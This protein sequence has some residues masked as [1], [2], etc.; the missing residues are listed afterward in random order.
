MAKKKKPIWPIVLT[1]FIGIGCIALLVIDWE[2]YPTAK[3]MERY[4]M[5]QHSDVETL[6]VTS[7][8]KPAEAYEKAQVYTLEY[9]YKDGRVEINTFTVR[10]SDQK[11]VYPWHDYYAGRYEP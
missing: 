8:E 7:V 2:R 5:S 10:E 3:E 11:A 4:L 1:F 9:T 6:V